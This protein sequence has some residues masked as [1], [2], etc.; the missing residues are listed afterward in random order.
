MLPVAIDGPLRLQSGLWQVTLPYETFCTI[1][2]PKSR[3]DE[4]L[5][6]VAPQ[7]DPRVAAKP[8]ALL[9]RAHR[10][11]RYSGDTFGRLA[12]D[13]SLIIVE[14]GLFFLEPCAELGT[15]R[16]HHLVGLAL[17]PPRQWTLENLAFRQGGAPHV[18]EVAAIIEFDRDREIIMG[19]HRILAQLRGELMRAPR[20]G[21]PRRPIKRDFDRILQNASVMRGMA[22]DP[23]GL[24]SRGLGAEDLALSNAPQVPPARRQGRLAIQSRKLARG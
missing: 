11:K 20:P 14:N 10:D 21:E 18:G 6:I 24:W 13:R 4:T 2:R 23:R 1:G 22:A 9:K 17:V 5:A 15:I 16:A 12:A 19:G 7:P 8:P 3:A